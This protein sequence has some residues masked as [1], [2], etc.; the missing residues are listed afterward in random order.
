MRPLKFHDSFSPPVETTGKIL[1]RALGHRLSSFHRNVPAC[2]PAMGSAKHRRRRGAII[3]SLGCR[4]VHQGQ[5]RLFCPVKVNY[6]SRR[7]QT[8]YSLAVRTG[9]PSLIVQPFLSRLQ[10]LYFYRPPSSVF[11]KG[12]NFLLS[13]S[14]LPE[15]G[16]RCSISVGGAATATRRTS[17]W[18]RTIPLFF[19]DPTQPYS[20]PSWERERAL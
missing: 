11:V 7:P 6:P 19:C 20:L 4:A 3:I 13:S 18:Q 16:G 1:S 12:W 15:T 9:R 14:F 17:P 10:W 2:L 5:G 8:F